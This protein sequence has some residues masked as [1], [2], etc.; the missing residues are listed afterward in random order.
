METHKLW[1][2]TQKMFQIFELTNCSPEQQQHQPSKWLEQSIAELL[3]L[4]AT[5]TQKKKQL[6]KFSVDR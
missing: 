4:Y 6:L 5:V 2:H 1:K 3:V